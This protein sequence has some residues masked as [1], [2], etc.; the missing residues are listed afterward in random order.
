MEEVTE[1]I[2]LQYKLLCN[3]VISIETSK[4]IKEYFLGYGRTLR[5]ENKLVLNST[6]D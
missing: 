2:I 4:F 6:T 5:L 3:S 1:Y